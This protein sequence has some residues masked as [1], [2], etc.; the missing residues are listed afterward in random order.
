MILIS[1]ANQ[2]LLEHLFFLRWDATAVERYK[3]VK[4]LKDEWLKAEIYLDG[5]YDVL[6]AVRI[7]SIKVWE[8]FEKSMEN[9]MNKRASC[10]ILFPIRE[11]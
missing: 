2:R 9:R 6:P 7:Y 3:N 11:Q 8:L 4:L 1:N 10:I 5:I